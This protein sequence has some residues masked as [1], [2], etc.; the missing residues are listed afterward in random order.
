MQDRLTEAEREHVIRALR[1]SYAQGKLTHEQL[2]ERL[3][4]LFA[5]GSRAELGNVPHLS[6]CVR[7]R[8]DAPA[9]RLGLSR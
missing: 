8:D 9:T 2:D 4:T 6:G 1:E 7:R 3:S 5:A